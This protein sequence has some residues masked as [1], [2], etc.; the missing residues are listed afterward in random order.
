MKCA[1]LPNGTGVEMSNCEYLDGCP[2]FNDQLDDMPSMA[3]LFKTRYCHDN[4]KSCARY[5]MRTK[6]G[7][8]HV[9][10]NLWPNQENKARELISRTKT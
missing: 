6:L 9:L 3:N 7:A 4:W 5:L 1:F 8:A 2:F 10:P